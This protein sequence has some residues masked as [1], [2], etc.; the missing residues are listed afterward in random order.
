MICGR[1][2]VSLTAL[3]CAEAGQYNL[4]GNNTRLSLFV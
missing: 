2:C 4:E 3:F 1:Q